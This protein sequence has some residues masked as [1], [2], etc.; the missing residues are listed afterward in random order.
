MTDKNE[1]KTENGDAV[2]KKR[3]TKARRRLLKSL[4]AGGAVVTVK[5]LPEG[6]SQPV[7]NAVILPAHA[8]VSQFVTLDCTIGGMDSNALGGPTPPFDPPG[9]VG[10]VDDFDP[11]PS[12][13][14]GINL[15]SI[16]GTVNPPATGAV[17]LIVTSNTDTNLSVNAGADQTGNV[18]EDG[19][20]TANFDPVSLAFTGSQL[21]SGGVTFRFQ[22]PDTDDC[23]IDITFSEQFEPAPP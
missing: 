11:K 12:G 22:F 21:T 9:P 2:Q 3:Y 18:N 6:W 8:G 1:T 10:A 4:T 15:S 13:G 23:V 5:G 14:T 17:N 16:S 20:Q 19:N 7:T